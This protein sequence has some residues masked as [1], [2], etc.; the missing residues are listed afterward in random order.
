MSTRPVAAFVVCLLLLSTT[1]TSVAATSPGNQLIIKNSS[2]TG[3]GVVDG[4][5]NVTHLWQS[6]PHNLSVFLYTGS[7]S[8][9]HR[10]CAELQGPGNNS[11][12]LGCQ[13][14]TLSP[15][16]SQRVNFTF[17]NVT[18]NVTGDQTLVVTVNQA[19]KKNNEVVA[20]SKKQITIL[21]QTGDPD[22]DGLTNKH[23][24]KY[25]TNVSKRDTDNDSLSDYEEV[26]EYDTNPLKPDTDSD[27]LR[28]PEEVSKGTDPRAKD[29][30][31]DGLL[32]GKE[33]KIGTNASNPDTDGDGLTDPVEVKGSTDPTEKD[34][35]SDGL[36]DYEETS[37]YDTDPTEEDTDNDGLNDST[38]IAIGTNPTNPDSD[39]DG[40][41]DGRE[42]KLGTNPMK[43]DTDG[44][45]LSDGF[46]QRF[47][48]NPAN[49]LITGGL[50]LVLL[51][52]IGAA[53]VLAGRSNRNWL[54]DLRND[55]DNP[56]S[57]S[58]QP[59]AESREI[60]T[61]AD[62]VLE[63]VREHGGRLPQSKIIKETDW[64]KS[65]VSRLLSR[66]EEDE[67]IS[68][69]NIGRKNIVVL[70]GNEPDDEPVPDT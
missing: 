34:T 30:D 44:D 23:E 6:K 67:Q 65:K 48:T 19:D 54:A 63:L 64:S 11:T 7:Q 39:D 40:L 50:Y 18:G 62:R 10:V 53:A 41:D 25:N 55:G 17:A 56:P 58:P 57:A 22:G 13:E 66:M 24:V 52:V 14:T 70:Y 45:G 60:V 59:T 3:P 26:K 12:A 29:T 31:E 15:N 27:G 68:K 49:S 69:I 16:A 4:E 28:D 8:G 51:G 2:Y 43:A 61:D 9:P 38:E 36:D 35:D 5:Y 33:V 21:R 32:D 46:E 20:Q 42:R 37:K 47:G 1:V